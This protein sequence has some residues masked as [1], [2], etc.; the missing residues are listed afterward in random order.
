M[1]ICSTGASDWEGALIV[2]PRTAWKMLSCSNTRG[3]ELL[4]SG[5]L[6][7]FKDGKSRKITVASI[8][9]YITRRTTTPSELPRRKRG[10]PRKS[11]TIAAQQSEQPAG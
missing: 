2:K 3:Y 1:S 6:V 9:D 10:R 7:S 8:K 5:E 11:T 4:N